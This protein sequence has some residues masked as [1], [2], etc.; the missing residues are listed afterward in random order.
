MMAAALI[1]SDLE[2]D[3]AVAALANRQYLSSR[4]FWLRQTA[5]RRPAD[6]DLLRQARKYAQARAEADLSLA[7]ERARRARLTDAQ[8]RREDMLSYRERV[9]NPLTC[10][11]DLFGVGGGDRV[12]AEL[13]RI[14]AQLASLDTEIAA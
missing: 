5:A 10:P 14:D 12:T 4:A 6:I 2:I 7:V 11:D 9:A 3:A 13:A 1:T 8:R